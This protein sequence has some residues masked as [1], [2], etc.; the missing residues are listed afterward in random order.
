[1]SIFH[2]KCYF[3]YLKQ[4]LQMFFSKCDA[5]TVTIT[6]ESKAVI[7]P[8]GISQPISFVPNIQVDKYH[9]KVAHSDRLTGLAI[10]QFI[11]TNY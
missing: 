3:E 11:A 5:E 10:A 4:T 9:Y 6:M 8:T 2:F 7:P 1:M